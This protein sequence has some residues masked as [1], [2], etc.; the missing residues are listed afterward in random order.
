MKNGRDFM[1]GSWHARGPD[2]GTV[3]VPYRTVGTVPYGTV[4]YGT[5]PV[6]YRTRMRHI[7]TWLHLSL[8]MQLLMLFYPLQA[9]EDLYSYSSTLGCLFN[10]AFLNVV[11]RSQTVRYRTVRFRY[12]TVITLRYGTVP[13]GTISFGTVP[14]RTVM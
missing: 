11:I 8:S 2:C 9:G 1:I 3:P 13:Y 4:P 6:P 14:Y 7:F 10:I 12:G 5:V